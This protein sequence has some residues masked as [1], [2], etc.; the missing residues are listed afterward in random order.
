VDFILITVP[1][2]GSKTNALGFIQY[3]KK[4][5][6]VMLVN[7]CAQLWTD[8]LQL[9]HTLKKGQLQ[10]AGCHGEGLKLAAMVMCREGYSVSIETGNSY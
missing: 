8:A 3:E 6:R 9:G 1:E 4:S 7:A 5:R 10:F 2:V